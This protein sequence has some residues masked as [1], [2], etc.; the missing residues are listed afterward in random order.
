MDYRQQREAGHFIIEHIDLIKG[1]AGL[2]IVQNRS[3]RLKTFYFVYSKFSIFVQYTEKYLY[4][5]L[6][7]LRYLLIVYPKI[8]DFQGKRLDLI[9][10]DVRVVCIAKFIRGIFI[11][12]VVRSIN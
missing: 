4:Q 6:F 11:S 12:S 10:S 2:R 7:L 5:C 9:G 1:V 8:F 3:V